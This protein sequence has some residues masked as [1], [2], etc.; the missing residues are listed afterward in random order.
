MADV[1][2]RR[3][4]VN[5]KLNDQRQEITLQCVHL[6]VVRATMRKHNLKNQIKRVVVNV[7]VLLLCGCMLKAPAPTTGTAVQPA[8]T[9]AAAPVDARN[10]P[11]PD[12]VFKDKQVIAPHQSIEK[13]HLQVSYN[14]KALRS[15]GGYLVQLSLVFRNME[16]KFQLVR[17]RVVLLNDKGHPVSAFTKSSFLKYA[18]QVKGKAAVTNTLIKD[19]AASAQSPAQ[20][21]VDWA[22]SYWLKDRFRISAQGI[23][24]GDLVYHSTNLNV[25]MKLIVKSGKREFAFTIKDPL[26]VVGDPPAV[27]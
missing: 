13:D 25:P 22:N 26:P 17:P 15:E 24:I 9:V 2:Q 8:K 16:D 11:V 27:H 19:A 12:T 6:S 4:V 1:A 21:R 20:E 23:E 18:A 10:S 7:S 5:E 14:L 3:A